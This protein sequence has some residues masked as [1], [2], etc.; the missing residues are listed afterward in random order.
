MYVLK[1]V[2]ALNTCISY[3]YTSEEKGQSSKEKGQSS[4]AG[5]GAN[6]HP[7]PSVARMQGGDL[8]FVR[9]SRIEEE[10]RQTQQRIAELQDDV[11]E[12]KAVIAELHNKSTHCQ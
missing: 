3:P 6:H 8:I 5:A 2:Y 9:I 7:L 4:R 12:L 1:C 11:K 10:N